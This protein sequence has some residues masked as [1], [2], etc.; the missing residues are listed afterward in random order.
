VIP[1]TDLGAQLRFSTSR[2]IQTLVSLAVMVV[3]YV[4]LFAHQ[5]ALLDILGG[6]YHK[7]HPWV[8]PLI[9]ALV[10]PLVAGL[11]GKVAAS[12]LKLIRLE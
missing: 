5:G 4:V 12:V 6:S 11:Y 7:Q 2:V 10:A 1:A 9:V 3:L 8:G